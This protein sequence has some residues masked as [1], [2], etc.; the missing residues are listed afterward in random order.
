MRAY[1][2]RKIKAKL[3]NYRVAPNK[4]DENLP[5]RLSKIKSVAILGGGIAGISATANL[6]ERGLILFYSKNQIIWAEK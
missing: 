1:L 4:P 3:Q 6:S 2:R 5:T